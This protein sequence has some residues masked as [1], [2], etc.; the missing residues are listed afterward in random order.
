MLWDGQPLVINLK[1]NPLGQPTGWTWPFTAGSSGSGVSA[2]RTY[3]TAG[4]LVSSETAAYRWD[5][6]GRLSQI[7]QQLFR[8]QAAAKPEGEPTTA[9]LGVATTLGYDAAGRLS[10]VSH[11]PDTLQMPS[12]WVIQDI[13]GPLD[14]SYSWDANGN[15]T[16]ARYTNYGGSGLT[17]S[18]TRSFT[19]QA[20]TNRIASV[21]DVREIG[22]S[23]SGTGSTGSTGTDTQTH[24]FDWDA[25]GKLIGYHGGSLVFERDAAGRISAIQAA[26]S[27]TTAYQSNALAQRVRKQNNLQTAATVYGDDE[28]WPGLSSYPLGSYR[29]ATSNGQALQGTEYLYLPTASGPMPIAVQIGNE[30]LAVHTDHLNTPRRLTN[31]Q[32]QA[33]WQWPVSGFGEVEPSTPV[34]GWIRPRLGSAAEVQGSTTISF[35]LRYPGQQHDAE[36]GLYYNH[37]RYYDPYLTVGYTEADPIGLQGGWNR[38]S[39]VGGN[40]LGFTDSMGLKS[41]IC[42]YKGFNNDWP[43]VFTC[44]NGDCAGWYPSSS[45]NGKPKGPWGAMLDSDGQYINDNDEV[46][47]S[48]CRDVKSCDEEFTDQCILQCRNNPPSSY[49][50][51]TSSCFNAAKDCEQKCVARSCANKLLKGFGK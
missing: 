25:S 24:H 12:P 41:Q 32:G 27:G 10:S 26:G 31:R 36:T 3:N 51:F 50:V 34:T 14:S 13:I 19:L 5:A 23:G 21:Q 2:A 44:V 40:P 6:A 18:L 33:A 16:Q 47:K 1:W 7:N 35:E 48:Y 45:S 29:M 15:R 22:Q 38:F 28:A 46:S 8:P 39:Y 49:N 20:G 30:L 4:Q 17:H 9:L 37:H 11:I 42:F 43:H